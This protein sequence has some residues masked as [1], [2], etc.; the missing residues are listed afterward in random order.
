MNIDGTGLRELLTFPGMRT[1]SVAWSPA[2][3][4]IAIHPDPL[5]FADY[6][7]VYVARSDSSEVTEIATLP[8]TP[9]LLAWTEDQTGLIF[10]VCSVPLEVNQIV[11]VQSDGD[12]RTLATI[13]IPGTPASAVPCSFGELSADQQRFALSPFYPFAGNGNLYVM[14]ISSG[15]CYQILSGYRV[16]SILWLPTDDLLRPEHE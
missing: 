15:Y 8:G 7:P 13:E 10:Y 4:Q 9:S 2:G 5:G 14:G 11:E 6:A 12:T 3:D 1:A 16:Q